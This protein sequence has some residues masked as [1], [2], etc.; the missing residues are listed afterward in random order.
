MTGT[1][2]PMR[3]FTTSVVLV[4][5]TAPELLCVRHPLF[6]TWMFPGGKVE[7]GEAPHIAAQREIAEEVGLG[8]TLVDAS[9]LPSWSE[10]GNTRLPHPIAM[11]EERLPNIHPPGRFYIDIVYVGIAL[12]AQISL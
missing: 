3:S 2:A 1:D 12:E 5:P 8:M 6:G 10:A 9:D 11:I 7:P 4:H